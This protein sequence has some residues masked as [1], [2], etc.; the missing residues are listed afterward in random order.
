MCISLL[1]NS[2]LNSDNEEGFVPSPCIGVCILDP[3]WGAYCIGC[4]RMG[5]EIVN[6]QEYTNK[7]KLQILER[8]AS[9]SQEDPA[10]YPDYK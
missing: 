2:R 3:T 6:W 4:K 1:G 5:M 9:L 8:L 10:D 7:E